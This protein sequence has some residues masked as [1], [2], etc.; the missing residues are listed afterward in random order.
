MVDRRALAEGVDLWPP[1]LELA[2][3]EGAQLP[4]RRFA[5]CEYVRDEIPSNSLPTSTCFVVG[6]RP[7]HTFTLDDSCQS[8]CQLTDDHLMDPGRTSRQEAQLRSTTKKNTT[9]RS[10]DPR[11][12]PEPCELVRILPRALREEGADQR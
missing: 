1:P 4:G 5:L 2:E 11:R 9:E 8:D 10:D 12:P 7:E 3:R 6:S